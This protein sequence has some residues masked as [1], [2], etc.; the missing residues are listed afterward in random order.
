MNITL[1]FETY[2]LWQCLCHSVCLEQ[3]LKTN[4]LARIF[5]D[6]AKV[7][8]LLPAWKAKVVFMVVESS[9]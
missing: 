4:L 3:L 5:T 7:K 2:S 1:C 9:H 8:Q 6:L